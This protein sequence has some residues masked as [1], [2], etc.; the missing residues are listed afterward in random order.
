VNSV[1]GSYPPQCIKSKPNNV[2]RRW[3][4]LTHYEWWLKQQV[5]AR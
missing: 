5:P 3:A 4:V 1:A 2:N